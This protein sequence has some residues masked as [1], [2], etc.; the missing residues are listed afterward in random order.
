MRAALV[1]AAFSFIAVGLYL[2]FSPESSSAPQPSPS[3]TPMVSILP[4][5]EPAWT[6]VCMGTDD[7]PAWCENI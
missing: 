7:E 4:S 6:H 5:G 2:V 1:I 3:P